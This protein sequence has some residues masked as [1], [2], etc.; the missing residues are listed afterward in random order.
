MSGSS[1]PAGSSGG[2]C[3]PSGTKLL[4]SATSSAF[5][6]GCLAAPAGKPFTVTFTNDDAGVPHN[7]AIY[8]DEAATQT[9]FQGDLVT[10]PEEI[11]YRV[12]ALPAGTYVFRCDVH[13]TT[14]KGTFIVG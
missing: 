6:T 5:D 2:T 4:V 10:G 7:L 14:M 9:L 8:S 13:P 3:E 12:P 11:T 1:A